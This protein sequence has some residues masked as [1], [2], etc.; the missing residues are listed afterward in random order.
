[1]KG[2]SIV[3]TG[4]I[5]MTF[6]SVKSVQYRAEQER[7]NVKPSPLEC[8]IISRALLEFSLY[9]FDENQTFIVMFSVLQKPKRYLI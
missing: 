1:M 8:E 9:L 3:I 4:T 5:I 2:L 6:N 7:K